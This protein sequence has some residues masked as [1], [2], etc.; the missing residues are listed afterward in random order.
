M[1]DKIHVCMVVTTDFIHD[2]R[3]RKEARS[4]L[5]LGYRVT[6]IATARPEDALYGQADNLDAEFGGAD[7]AFRPVHLPGRARGV[8][9][10]VLSTL[11]AVIWAIWSYL[12]IMIAVFRVR[13][14]LYHCHDI[15]ALALARLP[16]WVW[17]GKVVFDC[18]DIMSDIQIK[19][20][21]LARLRP[22]IAFFER[23][24]PQTA[25]GVIAAAPSFAARVAADSGVNET[26]IVPVLNCPRLHAME[27][28]DA[29]RRAFDIPQAAPV[30]LYLGSLNPDRGLDQL[31]PVIDDLV[32]E[33]HVVL[34]GPGHDQVKA[35]LSEQISALKSKA[36]VHL[37]G[38]VP[39]DDVPKMLMAATMTIIPNRYVSEAYNSLPNKLFEA[40]MAGRPFVCHDIPAMAAIVRETECAVILADETAATMASSL[41]RVLADSSL[42]RELGQNGRR[43]AERTYNW[44]SQ[45]DQI[46]AL[47]RRVLGAQSG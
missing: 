45:A 14:D 4:V 36:R 19:G 44:Q 8:S 23:H 13:A 18:H 16:A 2:R 34:M 28:T 43:A 41:N 26:S 30:L 1:K 32:L 33:A 31:I 15:D 40:M 25:H 21:I 6:M 3:V 5:D 27:E 42:A 47:Y 39:L 29:L 38:F 12:K 37:G 9:L 20:S 24:L 46:G 22:V 17:R 7:F 11:I 10:P 35:V